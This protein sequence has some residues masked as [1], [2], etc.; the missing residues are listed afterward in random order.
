MKFV[1]QSKAFYN[2]AS[3][4]GKV[5]SSKNAL[6]ILDNFLLELKDGKLTLTGSDTDSTL[7]ADIELSEAEGEGKICLS[8]RTLSNLLK[9]LPD[10]EVTFNI[11]DATLEVEISYPNG[12]FNLVAINGNEFPEY[13]APEDQGNPA[14]IVTEGKRIGKALDYTLFAVATEDF[15]AQMQGVYFD[16]AEDYVNFVATDTRKLVRYTDNNI[17]AGVKTSC[18]VPPKAASIIRSVFGSSE[19]LTLEIGSRAA[20]ISDGRFTFR[21][22][23][24]NGK[25]PDYNRVIPKNNPLHLVADRVGMLNLVR[26]VSIFVDAGYGLIRFRVTPET[27][28]LKSRAS[29]LCTAGRD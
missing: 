10:Q 24:M 12:T 11:N 27:V 25:Y 13:K 18:I 6:I 5:I 23:F 17:K 14:K 21:C 7:S 29:G 15:R 19:T 2:A 4:V 22:S 8:S 20:T 26:R 1:V 3:A 9:E 28:L 16:I